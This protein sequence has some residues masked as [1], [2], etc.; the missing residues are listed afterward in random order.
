MQ[1]P[2]LHP[3]IHP[4]H[5]VQHLLLQLLAPGPLLGQLLVRLQE[6]HARERSSSRGTAGM[7]HHVSHQHG[8]HHVSPAGCR[9]TPASDPWNQEGFQF[10][11][12][13]QWSLFAAPGAAHAN[14]PVNT[15]NIPHYLPASA[16]G[17]SPAAPG[18]ARP[19]HRAAAWRHKSQPCTVERRQVIGTAHN[20]GCHVHANVRHAMAPAGEVA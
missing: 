11:L 7:V 10:N 20:R 8:A 17:P 2:H 4:T 9:C 18:A 3:P 5:L 16:A 13:Q 1:P 12:H 19:P 15:K 14:P 6:E